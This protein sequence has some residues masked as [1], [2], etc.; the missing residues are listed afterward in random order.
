[1]KTEAKNAILAPVDGMDD[2]GTRLTEASM[3][4][5]RLRGEILRGAVRP[6]EKLKLVPLSERFEVS[7]GPLR[8]AAT[9]LVAEGL[10]TFEDQ[11]GFRVSPIS[12]TDL[13]DITA[14]R[15]RIESWA[16]R[17]ALAHGD[18]AWEGRVL[19]AVH[20]LD[21]VT[22]HDGSP[23]ARALFAEHHA[24]FHRA[25]VDACPSRHLLGFR[26]RLYALSERYRNLTAEFRARGRAHRE[27][28]AEHAALAEAAVARD[29]ERAQA[30]LE[31]HL[32]ETAE[33]L[34]AVV[35]ELFV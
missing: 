22:D 28:R 6:G 1:V 26:E 2:G 29:A 34:L 19:A 25:L 31:A 4:S 16:L 32:G 24:A 35:P 27:I 20:V 15:Q 8:E 14:T 18:L 9:R 33:Q 30:L 11:R 23:E 12:Q 5:A 21:R 3:L 10:L 7:R 13:L 17:D